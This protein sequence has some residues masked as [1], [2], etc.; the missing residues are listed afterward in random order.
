AA[1]VGAAAPRNAGP[2]SPRARTH[3]GPP[4][5]TPGPAT[6][7]SGCPRTPIHRIPYPR[8]SLRQEIVNRSGGLVR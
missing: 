8:Q 6:I 3:P 4:G 2:R 7:A 5:M 1:R